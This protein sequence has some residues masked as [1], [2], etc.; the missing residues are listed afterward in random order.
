MKQVSEILLPDTDLDVLAD[1]TV[2][3]S[4]SIGD[5]VA[6]IDAGGGIKQFAPISAPTGGGGTR[7]VTT[8]ATP[9]IAV[10]GQA[11]GSVALAKG[12]V[13]WGILIDNLKQVRVRLYST[14]AA[15]TADLARAMTTRAISGAYPAGT[16]ITLDV[17]LASNTN[18]ALDLDEKAI[19]GDPT[20]P[21]PT[22]TVYWTVDNL[23]ASPTEFVVT[24]HHTPFES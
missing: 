1:I 2:P 11:T 16:G 18:Y 22:T 3:D 4:A 23:T 6:V 10:N 12:T 7:T 21:G 17:V 8:F 20:T 15:R 24:L 9:S 14:V 13:V 5:V 19:A